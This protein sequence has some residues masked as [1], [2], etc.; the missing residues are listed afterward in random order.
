MSR[1]LAGLTDA[2]RRVVEAT[3]GH[4][5]VLAGPGSGKTHTV[6]AKIGHLFV[7]DAVLGPYRVAALTFT[8]AAAREMRGRLRRRGFS[9][10]DR[11]FC[12]TYHA[13][14]QHLLAYFGRF[15]GVPEDL[16]VD[17]DTARRLIEAVV[18]EYP[19]FTDWALREKIDEK[20]RRGILPSELA[21]P[22]DEYESDLAGAY[23][24]YEQRKRERGILDYADLILW[25][26]RLLKETPAVRER[27]RNAYRY[28]IADEF[29]D[30]DSQQLDIVLALAEGQSSTVVADDDQS[31]YAWRGA[32]RENVTAVRDALG[33]DQVLLGTNFRSDA[34][35]VEAALEVIAG[36]PGHSSKE[37]KAA[38]SARGAISGEL[39]EG[40][41]DEAAEVADR[42]VTV[43]DRTLISS[44]ADVALIART[45]KRVEAVLAALDDR[46]VS[47]FSRD[48]LRFEDSWD[49][50]LALAVLFAGL[51][52]G[53][54]EALRL[55]YIAIEDCG[56]DRVLD[57]D[58]L[59]IAQALTRVLESTTLPTAW[60]PEDLD[61]HFGALGI[62]DWIARASSSDVDARRRTANV[63]LL[64]K[65][66]VAEKGEGQD[67][68][69]VVRR[70]LGHDAVQVMTGHGSKGREFDVVFLI[71]LED[72]TLPFYKAL[73]D[74]TQLPEERRIFYVGLTRAK[75][76][77]VMTRVKRLYGYSKARSRFVDSIPR[78]CFTTWPEC[79]SALGSPAT[80][81]GQHDESQCDRIG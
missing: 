26:A 11:L 17:P 70:F 67:P 32:V 44:L 63:R 39:F 51:N 48:R 8:N 64:F 81:G 6:T 41:D 10:W 25:S 75:R 59:R 53:T 42:I 45:H 7:V 24:I 15:V 1:F 55:L 23:G 43:L 19:R 76:L 14:G 22:R 9:Q 46:G 47:W 62:W 69:F 38:S 3:T 4:Q 56:L 80:N 20:K 27:L 52:L 73:K 30:T 35:I 66:L 31:I 60:T 21:P 18:A 12:G 54:A 68:D 72:G 28:V 49:T 50:E 33:A 37:L 65:E 78:T 29:Q 16:D 71:G 40:P 57:E 34:V 61:R 79:L 74:E 2:Q 5:L 77:A 13:F 36:D 58:A